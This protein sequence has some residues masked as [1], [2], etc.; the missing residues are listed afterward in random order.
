MKIILC[1]L[2]FI[3]IACSQTSKQSIAETVKPNESTVL[4]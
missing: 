4:Q 1:V 2:L 3:A